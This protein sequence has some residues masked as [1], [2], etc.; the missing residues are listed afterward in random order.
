MN[1]REKI[2]S[3]ITHDDMER[4]ID[5]RDVPD[6]L[7]IVGALLP[8]VHEITETVENVQQQIFTRCDL[9]DRFDELKRIIRHPILEEGDPWKAS[10]LQQ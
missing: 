6:I 4:L 3:A 7:Y 10:G 8:G 5:D 1:A 9:M 2:D